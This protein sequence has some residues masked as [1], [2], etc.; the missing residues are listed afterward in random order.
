[1]TIDKR[2]FLSAIICPTFSWRDAN[3]A[4]EIPLEED[5]E[6]AIKIIEGNEIG[7]KARSIFPEGIFVS[8][9]KIDRAIEITKQLLE[10]IS[11][12]VIFE[13]TFQ[14]GHFVARADILVRNEDNTYRLIEVKSSV[15]D[16]PELVDDLAY[17]A[18]VLK[19]ANVKITNY[20]LMLISKNFRLGMN[21]KNMFQIIDHTNEVI[22]RIEEMLQYKD[23]IEKEIVSKNEPKAVFAFRC[24]DC[25][26]LYSCFPDYTKQESIFHLPR[27]S[28]KQFNELSFLKI[29]SIKK[30]PDT[31]R[32]TESQQFAR[33]SIK[34]NK[35]IKNEN[36]KSMLEEVEWPIYYLDFETMMPAIPIYADTAPY[37]QVPI[38]FSIHYKENPDNTYEHFEYLASTNGD[39][40][41]ELSSKL[42]QN[43]GIQGTIF[44]YSSFE[45]TIIKGLIEKFPGKADK[46]QRIVDR[47]YDLQNIVKCT[48]H[49]KYMGSYSIKKT[50]PA[51]VPSLN[52][53][54]LDISNGSM[55]MS[56][57]ILMVRGVIE[58]TKEESIRSSLLK[59]CER[60]TLAM[61]KLHEELMKFENEEL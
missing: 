38:Q 28:E 5:Y 54:D 52:Y 49:P 27:L 36:L 3:I 58:P 39:C 22:S 37:T 45:K 26:Y 48:Y 56:A 16:K 20:E 13:A 15:N 30:I 1:M 9:R 41:E 59:Y 18:M 42:I 44:S 40:R 57:F 47:I 31:F 51:I 35:L 23:I 4:E 21:S 60:D 7:D 46:L 17:T 53:S 55:A 2:I 43:L 32:L 50:L 6:K 10:N 29:D 34:S 61:V 8:E 14:I 11:V 33:D 24:K 25:K 12:K 19:L